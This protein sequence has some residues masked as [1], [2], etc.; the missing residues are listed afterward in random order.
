[1]E[2]NPQ[3]TPTDRKINFALCESIDDAKTWV[4]NQRDLIELERSGEEE[5]LKEI[6]AQTPILDLEKM[7]LSFNHLKILKVKNSVF[8]KVLV[9]F[10]HRKFQNLSKDKAKNSENQ[11]LDTIKFIRPSNKITTGDMLGLYLILGAGSKT[12]NYE[13][14]LQGVVYEITNFKLTLTMDSDDDKLDQFES[15]HKNSQFSLVRLVNNITYT[16]YSN[17]LNYLE[18]CCDD[19]T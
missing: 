14:L 13:P 9:T 11:D 15:Q 16:R 12:F 7:G 10:V 6:L 4:V 19:S 2:K 5:Q 8:G 3:P 18:Y 17:A 1:M